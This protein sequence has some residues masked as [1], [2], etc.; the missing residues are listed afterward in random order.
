MAPLAAMRAVA[1]PAMQNDASFPAISWHS[2]G[3]MSYAHD[4]SE[5]TMSTSP[6]C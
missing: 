4:L 6:S 3:F 5:C 2:Y 1:R